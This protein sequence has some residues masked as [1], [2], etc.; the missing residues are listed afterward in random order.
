MKQR[1]LPHGAFRALFSGVLITGLLA[2]CLSSKP[3]IK[4]VPA[5]PPVTLKSTAPAI[6]TPPPAP[7][8]VARPTPP[9][10]PARAPARAEPDHFPVVN[11]PGKMHVAATPKPAAKPAPA[12]AVAPVIPA[13]D[14]PTTPSGKPGSGSDPAPVAG[15]TA[16]VVSPDATPSN[17]Y[18]LRPGDQVVISIKGAQN[19]S[20]E[21]VVDEAGMITLIYLG[22]FKVDGLTASEVERKV[23]DAYINGGIFKELYVTAFIPARRYTMSGDVKSPGP[24]PINGRMTLLQAIP[25]A[26]GFTEFANKK[27]ILITRKGVTTKANYLDIQRNPAKD[28]EIE[29]DDVVFVPRDSFGLFNSP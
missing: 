4:P 20:V 17:T 1:F 26:G 8:P 3:R 13:P 24:F 18:R 29:P 19:Q 2:G 9:A 21:D 25:T 23:R 28:I 27:E 6:V 15:P 7:A 12:A 5:P 11:V 10:P 16:P 14:R 22:E